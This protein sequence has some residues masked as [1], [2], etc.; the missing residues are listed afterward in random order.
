MLA[1]MLLSLWFLT[2][3]LEENIFE[4]EAERKSE[5]GTQRGKLTF[6]RS[7]KAPDK[8]WLKV[9]QLM[10]HSTQWPQNPAH[11]CREDA[12]AGDK[13]KLSKREE[14][15]TV[16]ETTGSAHICIWKMQMLTTELNWW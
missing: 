14:M 6:Y 13:V 9:G 4:N 15:E 5:G 2:S 1:L 7:Q 12:N 16:M 8:S 10:I 3:I 11:N